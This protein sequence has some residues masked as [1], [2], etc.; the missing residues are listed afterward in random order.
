MK[1]D[2]QKR[3]AAGCLW[4]ESARLGKKVVPPGGKKTVSFG[5]KGNSGE[6]SPG[7]GSTLRNK[8]NSQAVMEGKGERGK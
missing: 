6:P 3:N 8:G 2:G 7:Y 4:A 1:A 5:G